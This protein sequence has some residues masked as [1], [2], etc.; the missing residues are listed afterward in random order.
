MGDLVD[1]EL[2]VE[3]VD[4]I[5]EVGGGVGCVVVGK[6]GLGCGSGIGC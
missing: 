5:V 6:G 2:G 4:E 3:L 1:V